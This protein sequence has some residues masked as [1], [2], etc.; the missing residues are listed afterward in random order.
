MRQAAGK[1]GERTWEAMKE[2]VE[3][4]ADRL[5]GE[6]ERGRE[7]LSCSSLFLSWPLLRGPLAL[8]CR[9][10]AEELVCEE[11]DALRSP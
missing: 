10:L 11:Q 8:A 2:K 1:A 3:R 9:R 6:R 7:Q 5:R 4:A